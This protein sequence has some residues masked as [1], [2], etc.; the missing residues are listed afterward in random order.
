MTSLPET[1]VGLQTLP[2]EY[3]EIKNFTHLFSAFANHDIQLAPFLSHSSD[4]KGLEDQIKDKSA[5]YTT[6]MRTVLQRQIR[7]QMNHPLSDVQEKNIAALTDSH[8]FSVSCGH[9][10]NLAGGP[11]YMAY[12]ILTVIALTQ[13][14]QKEFPHHQFVPFHWLATE[15][16]DVDEIC[17]FR[18]FSQKIKFQLDQTGAV[19]PMN[20]ST[21][22][23]QMR[24]IQDF[25][26]WMASTYET[27]QTWFRPLGHG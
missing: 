17:D 11:V 9:Q 24:E 4:L 20:S 7:S 1:S 25:P 19:G 27:G 8:T 18:F 14:L 10:L 16:H 22:P 5:S 26:E 21:L 13:K 6:E 15:D 2:L 23:A 3:R 12:K